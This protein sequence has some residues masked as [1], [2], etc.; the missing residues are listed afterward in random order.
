[1]HLALVTCILKSLSGN[2]MA[3]LTPF[4][5]LAISDILTTTFDLVKSVMMQ[6]LNEQMVENSM[7]ACSYSLPAGFN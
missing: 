2:I 6:L 7:A 5:D 3:R 1:M 4:I